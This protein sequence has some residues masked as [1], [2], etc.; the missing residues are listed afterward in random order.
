MLQTCHCPTHFHQ[1][2]QDLQ[3]SGGGWLWVIGE[4]FLEG[5]AAH[6]HYEELRSWGHSHDTALREALG[7]GPARGTRETARPLYFAGKA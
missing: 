2:D 6:R 4:A 7:F 5:L 1:A 3:M